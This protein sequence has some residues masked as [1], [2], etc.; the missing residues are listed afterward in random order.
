MKIYNT[1]VLSGGGIKGITYIGALKCLDQL[2]NEGKIKLQIETICA[3]SV[4]CILGL[5]YALDYTW[6]EMEK[7]LFNTSLDSLKSINFFHFITKYGLD[8][9]NKIMKWLNK[10][11]YR[12]ISKKNYTFLDLYCDKGINFQVMTTNLN[13]YRYEKYSYLTTPDTN[14]IDAIRM[15]ISVPFAFTALKNQNG[16]YCVDGCIIDNYPIEE[17]ENLNGVLG[18]KIITPEELGDKPIYKEINDLTSF[19]FN[20]INCYLNRR[21]KD[22]INPEKVKECTIYI[23]CDML[24]SLNFDLDNFKKIKFIEIGYNSVLEFFNNF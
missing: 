5:L 15:A 3:V 23:N 9:C 16:D 21:E 4:G 14:I 19:S 12:K 1:L 11:I 2:Q 20:V 24:F 22:A 7:E 6:E 10:M 8:N 17:F 13:R 18:L